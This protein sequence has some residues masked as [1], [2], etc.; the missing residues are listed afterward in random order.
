MNMQVVQVSPHLSITVHVSVMVRK[1]TLPQLNIE[2]LFHSPPFSLFFL[3]LLL[4]YVQ[5]SGL[6]RDEGRQYWLMFIVFHSLICND[7]DDDDDDDDDGDG[8]GDGRDE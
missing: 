5:R 1:L 6:K 4:Y 3:S 8:D 7:D 2:V